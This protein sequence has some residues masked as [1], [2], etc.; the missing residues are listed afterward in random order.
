MFGL[1]FAALAEA[2]QTYLVFAINGGV[3]LLGFLVL[4]FAHFPPKGS[5][6]LDELHEEDASPETL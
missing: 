6:R 1:I 2:Q 5:R 3:A 4:L